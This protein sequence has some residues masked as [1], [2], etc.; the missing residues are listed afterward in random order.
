MKSQSELKFYADTLVVEALLYDELTK[1]AEGGISDLISGVTNY[2]NGHIDPNNKAGSVIDILA[3]GA[4]FMALR[5]MNLSWLGIL[6]GIAMNVFHIDVHSILSSIYNKIKGYVSENKQLSSEQVDGMVSSSVQEHMTMPTEEEAKTFLESKQFNQQLRDAK[7]LKLAMREY[8]FKKNA[9]F[10]DVFS[11]KKG[12]TGSLLTTVLSWFFKVALAAAG[13]MVAGDVVNKFLGRP[14]V[15]DKTYQAGKPEGD[16]AIVPSAPIVRSTQ[17]K[18]K[19]KSSYSGETHNVNSLWSVPI[20]NDPN[21]IGQMIIDFAK[22][23]YDGL[24]NLDGVIRDTSGFN[25]VKNR[26]TWY[27]QSSQGDNMVFIPK[28]FHTKKDIADLFIDEVAKKTT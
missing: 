1:T 10:L 3:P 27:N 28:Y 15:L 5:A 2:V 8:Q 7:F 20:S 19:V 26:I 18:F 14:N 12:S 25:V 17:T 4:V 6:L 16:V 11:S 9:G 13:F 22:E 23:V 24:N 21:S